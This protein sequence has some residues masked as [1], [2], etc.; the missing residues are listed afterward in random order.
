MERSDHC[1]ST[2][3]RGGIGSKALHGYATSPV[4]AL[5]ANG[6]L[7]AELQEDLHKTAAPL[8]PRTGETSAE[9]PMDLRLASDIVDLL[10][11]LA[12]LYRRLGRA[13]AGV[14]VTPTGVRIRTGWGFTRWI[15]IDR[16]D[17]FDWQGDFCVALL[18]DGKA[19]RV[20]AV[21]EDRSGDMTT[22]NNE[23][24]AA[25]QTRS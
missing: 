9:S 6:G 22:L 13:I 25:C 17:R 5:T 12:P 21:A 1:A 15:P 14:S 3:K 20:R 18:N 4:A 7:D 23:L 10:E 24:L 11:P 8:R 19:V 2:S 16:V